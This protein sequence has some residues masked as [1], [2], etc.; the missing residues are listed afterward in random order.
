[1]RKATVGIVICFVTVLFAVSA[2]SAPVL[3]TAILP[4][5]EPPIP[6]VA[7]ANEVGRFPV[8]MYHRI[9]DQEGLWIRSRENFRKDLVELFE[10]G[11]TLVNLTEFLSGMVNVPAGRTPAVLTFDDSTQGQF[12]Y[13]TNDAGELFIDP[14]CAVGMLLEAY[15]K[16]PELGLAGTFYINANPFGQRP[17]SEAKL[18]HLVELGFE[19]GNHTFT[20]PKLNELTPER[21][22]EELAKIVQYVSTAVPN[23][24][25]LSLA[26]PFGRAPL[27]RQIAVAGTWNGVNYT[28]RYILEVGSDPA[29]PPT[30]KK[31][32]AL[33]IPRIAVT[34]E[35][36]YRWLNWLD[37]ETGRKYIS[38]GDHSVTTVPDN[39]QQEF[40]GK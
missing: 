33:S 32:N 8:F 5:V 31:Y 35:L 30:H 25:P 6:I 38:D 3:S 4:V 23:Y 17:H 13:L 19:I 28:N 27:D 14:D 2:A 24:E 20:H 29:Y 39:L 15:E 21:V 12:N 10:R 18:R 11:Y 7:N 16:W 40:K 1:M 34:D 37:A 26:L 9:A 36:F 22:Q